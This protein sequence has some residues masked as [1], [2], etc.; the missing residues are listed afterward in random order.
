MP[1]G[2]VFAYIF[3]HLFS[4][5]FGESAFNHKFDLGFS[6]DN[7]FKCSASAHKIKFSCNPLNFAGKNVHTRDFD[8]AF[9][10]A[11]ESE[12]IALF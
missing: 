12:V 2:K 5:F 4:L 6:I 8:E 10:S 1:V 9:F 7:F 3:S 11:V